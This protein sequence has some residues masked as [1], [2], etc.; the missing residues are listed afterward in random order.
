MIGG[1]YLQR[2]PYGGFSC[3]FPITQVILGVTE[4]VGEKMTVVD[5]WVLSSDRGLPGIRRF[6]CVLRLCQGGRG[7]LAG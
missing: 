1:Q 3:G 4:A 7:L 5:T 6:T 2:K